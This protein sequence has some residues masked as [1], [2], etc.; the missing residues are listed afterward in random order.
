MI[1]FQIPYH[2]VYSNQRIIGGVFRNLLRFSFKDFVSSG[3]A[4]LSRVTDYWS[5]MMSGL[6][7]EICGFVYKSCTTD[8]FMSTPELRRARLRRPRPAPRPGPRPGRRPGPKPGP[9]PRPNHRPRPT[10]RPKA[11]NEA[12][13]GHLDL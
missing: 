11:S 3:H 12:E 13:E 9:R 2:I 7:G 4:Y 10:R 5:G 1:L 6:R 8:Y